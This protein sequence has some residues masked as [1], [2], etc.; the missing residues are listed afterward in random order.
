[1]PK[2]AEMLPQIIGLRLMITLVKEI[3]QN[4]TEIRDAKT[5]SFNIIVIT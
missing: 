2:W 1:M 4:I 3:F 5:G